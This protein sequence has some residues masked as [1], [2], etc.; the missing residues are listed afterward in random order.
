MMFAKSQNEHF[1]EKGI[2]KQKKKSS[3]LFWWSVREYESREL[4]KADQSGRSFV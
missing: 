4:K 2:F 3:G 1:K